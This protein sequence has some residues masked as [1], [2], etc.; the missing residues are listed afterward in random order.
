MQSP[1][2]I[3]NFIIEKEFPCGN[4]S[5]AFKVSDPNTKQFFY[6]KLYLKEK[7]GD[8]QH[9]PGYKED[10]LKYLK[11]NDLSSVKGGEIFCKVLGYQPSGKITN[12]RG[13]NSD[14]AYF[15]LEYIDGAELFQFIVLGAFPPEITRYYFLRFMNAIYFL[16]EMHVA[17]RDIKDYMIMIDKQLNMR[18]IDYGFG[19]Q[20]QKSE[21]KKLYKD[22]APSLFLF[23][24]EIVAG[25]AYDPEKADI[26]SAGVMLFTLTFGFPPFMKAANNDKGYEKFLKGKEFWDL[27]SGGKTQIQND[28]ISIIT[29]MLNPDPKQRMSAK[30]VLNSPWAK[31]AVANMED[32]KK[33]VTQR[34]NGFN[35]SKP[36]LNAKPDHPMAK[37]FL[38][39]K[40]NVPNKQ[41]V[42]AVANSIPKD[43]PP[44]KYAS[45]KLGLN[46][47]LISGDLKL[48]YYASLE[49]AKMTYK[50]V[51]PK[52][53]MM[54]YTFVSDT[55]GIPIVA[56]VEVI[57][58]P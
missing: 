51:V 53:N 43:L 21:F 28:I 47:N 3:D 33:E 4:H 12:F 24:P 49:F 10:M 22:P 54:Q 34:I 44:S 6:L 58:D 7:V 31:G 1:P 32:I 41:S 2:M 46:T 37:S 40:I 18:I 15:I 36:D 45:M 23:A 52:N 55:T 16:H 57:Y 26:F 29:G 56:T 42:I 19:N 14:C 35:K 17:H 30:D 39:M 25:Q 5:F 8:I 20:T 13:M 9:I 48:V 38:E 11:F 50:N 27:V